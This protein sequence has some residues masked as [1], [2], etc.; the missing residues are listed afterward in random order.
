MDAPIVPIAKSYQPAPRELSLV[1]SLK[2][3]HG[4]PI[5]AGCWE[6]QWH[7]SGRW[8]RIDVM[9]LLEPIQ[10]VER[11]L[12]DLVPVIGADPE[13]R[14][15]LPA[16]QEPRTRARD[17]RSLG[18]RNHAAAEGMAAPDARQPGF[19]RDRLESA[20]D[21]EGHDPF[22]AFSGHWDVSENRNAPG[23]ENQN[24]PTR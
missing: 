15:A 10:V 6:S 18:R 23:S 17:T 3:G 9:Q 2:V 21:V 1:R 7:S 22:A 14:I 13:H 12:R 4:L 11:R 8:R 20:R 16:G 5:D 24:A 19:G